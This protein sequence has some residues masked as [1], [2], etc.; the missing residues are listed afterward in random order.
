MRVMTQLG[1]VRPSNLKQVGVEGGL[2]VYELVDVPF[3]S[4]MSV[5]SYYLNVG[6]GTIYGYLVVQERAR[7]PSGRVR[8]ARL[9]GV[10]NGVL[11]IDSVPDIQSN[12]VLFNQAQSVS[13]IE[14]FSQDGGLYPVDVFAH[15]NIRMAKALAYQI[16]APSCLVPVVV[17]LG[18]GVLNNGKC[19]DDPDDPALEEVR[20]AGALGAHLVFLMEPQ[21][22][23]YVRALS[24]LLSPNAVR[25]LEERSIAVSNGINVQ[26][27]DN[28]VAQVPPPEG[29]VVG[30]FGRVVDFKGARGTFEVY[31]KMFAAGLVSRVIVTAPVPPNAIPIPSVFET[32][33]GL[34]KEY[35][36]KAREAKAF[37]F[38]SYA[39]GFPTTV[40]ECM[41]VGVI[42][43][44]R[45]L[46]W[47]TTL[48]SDPDY[49]FFYSSLEEAV[50]LVQ[51]ALAEYP[52][53]SPWCMQY[54][55]AHYDRRKTCAVWLDF[56]AKVVRESTPVHTI[57]DDEL[58]RKY[59][60]VKKIEAAARSLGDEFTLSEI[61]KAVGG[62]PRFSR[63]PVV[64]LAEFAGLVTRLGF[65]DTLRGPEP[66]YRRMT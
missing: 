24:R 41:A 3:V 8:L 47:S 32:H 35:M 46:P 43:V 44:M 51:K 36:Y 39:E 7:A 65:R 61:V 4:V 5:N 22:L 38:N 50:V 59:P 17:R 52:T 49:P 42:P 29:A 14:M 31:E 56:I 54:V 53:W 16:S 23:L 11:V 37:L 13:F 15:Y 10:N 62:V 26:Y 48:I 25:I 58:R 21:R 60:V 19:Y 34:G 12:T 6:E 9:A 57:P 28:V 63:G 30:Y 20:S 40:I 66:S 45:R 55:R 33:I 1:Y 64:S 2:P 18:N 27:C